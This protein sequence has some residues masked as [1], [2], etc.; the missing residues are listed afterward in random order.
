MTLSEIKPRKP[1]KLSKPNKI[2]KPLKPI[3]IIN[4]KTDKADS[5]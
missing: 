5:N 3:V 1:T 4:T 2:K